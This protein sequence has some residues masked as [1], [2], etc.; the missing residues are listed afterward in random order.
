MSLDD[1]ENFIRL[2]VPSL[3]LC[4][5]LKVKTAEIRGE[6]KLFEDEIQS[7]HSMPRNIEFTVLLVNEFASLRVRA[8]INR[9]TAKFS[10]IEIDGC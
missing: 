9:E 6:W 5:E 10:N 2:Y 8:K 3:L 1:D 4:R 7:I